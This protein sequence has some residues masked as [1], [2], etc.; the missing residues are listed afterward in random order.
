MLEAHYLHPTT[1]VHVCLQM[2]GSTNTEEE[3]FAQLDYFRGGS[4]ITNSTG[5]YPFSVVMQAPTSTCQRQ[6]SIQAMC[7]IAASL[8]NSSVACRAGGQL[9]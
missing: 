8:G 1:K 5:C 6:S 4:S 9:H 3:S 7:L 2:M